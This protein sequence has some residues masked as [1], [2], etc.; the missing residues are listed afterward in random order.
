[1]TTSLLTRKQAAHALGISVATLDRIVAAGRLPIVRVTQRSI[2]IRADDVQQFVNDR[3][4]NA[5]APLQR[6]SSITRASPIKTVPRSQTTGVRRLYA[7]PD[8][9]LT[10]PGTQV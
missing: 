10:D 5:K 8:P 7:L 4:V 1:M 2:R 3:V 6:R 9:L